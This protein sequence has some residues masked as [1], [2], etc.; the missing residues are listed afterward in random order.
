M[1]K[2]TG[3]ENK[4]QVQPQAETPTISPEVPVTETPATTP[5]VTSPVTPTP[6]VTAPTDKTIPEPEAVKEESGDERISM[7]KKELAEVVRELVRREVGGKSKTDDLLE[8]ILDEQRA[9]GDGPRIMASR[10]YAE[11]EID[12]KDYLDTPVVLFC[13][14]HS[15]I[16]MGDKRF[17]QNV[18]TP[19]DTPIRFKH[20]MRYKKPG[21]SRYND[22]MITMSSVSIRSKKEAIWMKKHTLFGIKYFEDIQDAQS[23]SKTFSDRLVETSMWL[24]S[25]TEFEVIERAKA[26]QL[27]ITSNVDDIRRRLVYSITEKSMQGSLQDRTHH[28][29]AAASPDFDH[30]S[31]AS[32]VE[33]TKE[34]EK[35]GPPP[36]VTA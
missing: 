27:E 29:V 18:K 25:M 21:T 9:S 15:H 8:L 33:A 31:D 17:G 23:V 6:E 22:E 16:C 14:S 36:P 4:E 2:E 30:T 1:T 34:A 12:I 7:S 3:K 13:Y 20:L 26:E 35:I 5:Q 11:A 10:A 24:N 32:M 19:Y 28:K